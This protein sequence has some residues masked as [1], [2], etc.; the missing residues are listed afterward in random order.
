MQS[1]QLATTIAKAT[2]CIIIITAIVKKL[3]LQLK[4]FAEIDLRALLGASTGSAL[5]FR[6]KCIHCLPR[7]LHGT[8]ALNFG[9]LLITLCVRYKWPATRSGEPVLA[10]LGLSISATLGECAL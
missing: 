7:P 8:S 9:V 1:S 6:T 3:K 4:F 2:I 5:V 10:S